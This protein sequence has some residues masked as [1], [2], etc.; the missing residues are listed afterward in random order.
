MNILPTSPERMATPEQLERYFDDMRRWNYDVAYS[1][2]YAFPL[3]ELRGVFRKPYEDFVRMAHDRGCPA[4]IQ[5]Q[6]TVGFLDDTALE[7][8]QYNT[9]NTPYVYQHYISYG[10]K[11]FFGS[12]AAPGWLD[13]I[14]T[15]AEILRGY[16]FD[17]VVFEEPMFKFDIP[18]TKD[19]LFERFREAFPDL[20]YPTHQSESENYYRLQ[21][22]KSNILVDFYRRLA[23]FARKLGFQKCGIMPWFFVPTHENT[24]METWNSCC[25]ISK[26]AFL[27]DVDFI[28]V[29]M[30][31]DNVHAEAI[32][33]SGGEQMPQISYLE[34]LAQNLGKPIISVN[35][36][37]DEHILNSADTPN[38]LLPFEFFARFTLAAAAA[39][40]CGMSRHWYGKDYGRDAAHMALLSEVNQ[41]LP[42]LGSPISP[43]A[44]IFSYAAMTRR[45]PRPWTETWKSFWFIAQQLLYENKIPALVFFAES[46]A[47]SLA[48][49]PETKILIFGEYF[50]IP[51]EEISM[52]EKWLKAD[53]SRR[54]LYIG[55]RNGYRWK[56]DAPYFEFRPK[57]PEMLSLFGCDAEQPIRVAAHGGKTKL[58]FI[59]KNPA[60][61]FIGKNPILKCGVRGVPALKN[62]AELEILYTA[63]ANNESIIFR[64]RIAGGGAAMFVGL[65][66]DGC[67]NNLPIDLFVR[68]LLEEAGIAKDEYP[69]VQTKSDGIL[70]NRTA[71]GFII[72]SNCS[73]AHAVCSLPLKEG[74]LWDVRKGAFLQKGKKISVPPLDFR[75]LK[76][77]SDAHNLLD[78]Q[79]QIYLNAVDDTPD[80]LSVNGYFGRQVKTLLL[81][82]P[83]S[84]Q[85]ENAA[86][87]YNLQKQK[88][89]YKA[90]ITL[91][92]RREGKLNFKFSRL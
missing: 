55:A 91:P 30:Q 39:A 48:R 77:I 88:E 75:L 76:I 16:G 84:I 85:F 50:P 38:N 89:W 2:F 46:L 45:V 37:T 22:L 19:T 66:T 68:H 62:S 69:S 60:D 5:I 73:G 29:R 67:D 90:F 63:G 81:R 23:D 43:V 64:R 8:A 87:S 86:A 33:G 15:I 24:P 65:S 14:K 36:P 71:N 18:G 61:A 72:I 42:R 54:L 28:V 12:F 20:P 79:G 21:E 11:N 34:N 52:L 9:D 32:I 47:E 40:P 83:L 82:K 56:L 7:C 80:Y 1:A 59:S 3:A 4:C 35:N 49:H 17:W 57:P 53:A 13:Y 51:P 41:C 92:E 70:W 10:K 44:M 27:S 74:R 26:L 31:P 78:I 6:S 25:P 58:N